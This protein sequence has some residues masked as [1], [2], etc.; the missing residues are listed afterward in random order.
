MR[1]SERVSV[2]LR[3]GRGGRVVRLDSERKPVRQHTRP[4][5]RFILPPWIVGTRAGK[6]RRGEVGRGNRDRS[7][8]ISEAKGCT[9][10]FFR[11]FPEHADDEML[12]AAFGKIWEVTDL[13]VP[14]KKDLAGQRFGFARFSPGRDV[15]SLVEEA[16]N[17]WIESFKIRAFKPRFERGGQDRAFDRRAE[18]GRSG[19]SSKMWI[20]KDS[21]RESGVCYAEVLAGREKVCKETDAQEVMTPEELDLEYQSSSADR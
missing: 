2:W 13:Y 7:E 20:K 9:T 4:N 11:N 14:F 3:V 18:G 19:G 8:E 21:L 17:I 15:E 12:K 5:P 1:E 10:I 16:N 6:G